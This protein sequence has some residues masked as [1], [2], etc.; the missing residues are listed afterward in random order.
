MWYNVDMGFL[1]LYFILYVFGALCFLRAGLGRGLVTGGRDLTLL[2][3]GLLF[4]ILVPLI[5]TA[6]VIF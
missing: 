6:R 2:P 5:Q 1:V 4:W 3:L